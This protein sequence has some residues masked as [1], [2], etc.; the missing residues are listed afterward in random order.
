MQGIKGTVL[1]Y[2][3]GYIPLIY[4][5]Y[6]YNILYNN[7]NSR[8]SPSSMSNSAGW[9]EVNVGSAA[10]K[11]SRRDFLFDRNKTDRLTR[12]RQVGRRWRKR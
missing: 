7:N 8:C 9:S 10:F 3:C 6:N 4:C 5:K 2:C 12:G 11:Q 1:E